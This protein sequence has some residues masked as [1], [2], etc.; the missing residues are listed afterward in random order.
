MP[1]RADRRRGRR[2]SSGSGSAG[3]PGGGERRRDQPA[4]RP[5]PRRGAVCGPGC[6]AAGRAADG[7]PAGKRATPARCGAARADLRDMRAHRQATD[8]FGLRWGVPAVPAPP[9]GH[10]LLPL[11]SH[12]TGRRSGRGPPTG[13]CPLPGPTATTMRTVRQDPPDRA[14]RPRW[15]ARYLQRLLQDAAGDL[16]PLPA[17]PAVLVRYRPEPCLRPMRSARHSGLRALWERT[18]TGRPLARGPSL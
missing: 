2:R 9:A 4:G 10:G 15:A 12:Q 8:P 3:G 1:T 14:P 7:G 16:Q 11:R 18:S 17:A 5:G 6:A 13:M